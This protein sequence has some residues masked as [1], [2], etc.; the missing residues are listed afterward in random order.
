MSVPLDFRWV[1]GEDLVKVYE[2]S[3]G[4]G[5]CF[6]RE[7]G[8]SLAAADQGRITGI[9]LGTVEGDPGIT[10]ESHI[11]VGS[12]AQWYEINDDLPQFEERPPDTWASPSKAP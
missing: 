4:G 7:C 6:C 5:W 12:K 1:S 11:F 9:T 10:P 3:Q 8:S 2:T